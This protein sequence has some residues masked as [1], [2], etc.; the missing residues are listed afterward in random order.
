[1]LDRPD[2][3]SK[4]RV[5]LLVG[6][7]LAKR[8]IARAAAPDDDLSASGLSSLGVVNLMLSVE[9]EFGIKIPDRQMTPANFRIIARI[10][11]LVRDLFGTGVT[12]PG[13]AAKPGLS[14]A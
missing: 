13:S 12:E 6:R 2:A 8:A 9:A 7:L 11:V 3:D 4:E 1:M 5:S 14:V 10:D